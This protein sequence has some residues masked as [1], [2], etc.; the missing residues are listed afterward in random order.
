MCNFHTGHILMALAE[1][2]AL[3]DFSVVYPAGYFLVQAFAVKCQNPQ[4]VYVLHPEDALV[5]C[6]N[7]EKAG[8]RALVT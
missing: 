2:T 7:L 3:I 5:R 1:L 8:W 4:K 6:V